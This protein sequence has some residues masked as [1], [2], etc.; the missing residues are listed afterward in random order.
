MQLR[1]A[2]EEA[3][4]ETVM[5]DFDAFLL[6]HAACERK[7][8]ATGMWFV[9]RYPDRRGLID[10][11]IRF[12]R[13]ELEHFHRVVRVIEQRGLGLAPDR[14]D[15]YVLALRRLARNDSDAH[16]LDRLLIAGVVE[17]RGTERF[18]LV[19]EALQAGEL[20]DMYLDLTRSEAR[21]HALF[22]TLA[23]TWFS[24]ADVRGRLDELLD[25]EAAIVA[26]LP[27]V[28]AVH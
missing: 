27:I 15:E 18:G 23:R 1:R 22:V 17:A 10:P 28:A 3:W 9:S 12:A 20:K 4:L 25:A 16:L 11:M 7:A 5:A 26:G 14:K 6:D 24:E 19:A 21:H 13:E 8:S 2:T